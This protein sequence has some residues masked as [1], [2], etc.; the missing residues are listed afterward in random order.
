MRDEEGFIKL[1]II[2]LI[3]GIFSTLK[4]SFHF[5]IDF[6]RNIT[7]NRISSVLSLSFTTRRDTEQVHTL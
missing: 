2:Y 1:S 6:T 7:G 4:V 5:F 3:D